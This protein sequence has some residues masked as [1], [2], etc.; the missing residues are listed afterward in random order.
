MVQR[1]YS[2]LSGGVLADTP[3]ADKRDLEPKPPT[4]GEHGS[5]LTKK[6]RLLFSATEFGDHLYVMGLP[7]GS[8]GKESAC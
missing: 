7:G 8:G 3:T 6:T 2:V 5:G 4:L 1:V